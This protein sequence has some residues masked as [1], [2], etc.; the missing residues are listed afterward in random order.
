MSHS[1]REILEY[2]ETVATVGASTDPD[3]EANSVPRKLQKA[4]FRVIPVNPHHSEVLGEHSYATLLDI[5]GRVDVVQVFR[6]ETEAPEIGREAV[7]IGAKALWLQIGIRSA[8]ARR[9]AE[10]AG[11][12][13]VEDRCMAVETAVNRINKN[14][15]K[16][17][18]QV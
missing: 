17:A 1:P 18:A 6:P 14:R 3:K 7:R 16:E 12:D 13:Y 5:P 8:E 9:I 11:L 2:A 15:P 10:E 4:G